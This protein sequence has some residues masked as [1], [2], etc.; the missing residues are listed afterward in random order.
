MI[1][2]TVVLTGAS[3]GMGKV[4]ALA[5]LKDGYKVI[6][7]DINDCDIKQE[8][9]KFI[10][11]DLTN[12]L[13]RKNLIEQIHNENNQIYAII[14]LAGIFMME[15][16]VEG[17]SEHLQKIIDVNF[18]SSYYLNK[19][20]FSLLDKDSRII[21]MSSELARYSPQPFMAYY[22]ISKKMVDAYTDALRR[23]CNYIGIKVIKIQSGSM[24]T[25]MLTKANNEYEQMV[26]KTKYFTSPLNKMKYMMDRELKKNADP[27]IIANLIVK[28]LNS[29]KPK[30]IYRVK[31]SFALKAMNM[32]PENLQDNIYKKVIK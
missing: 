14:N 1:N 16:I 15:S 6:G 29:K 26:S 3:G 5:L 20:L 11:A 10:K 21:N 30:I 19:G 7:I 23:E 9:F 27:A 17:E 18:F 24:K 2:K 12:S 32:L 8:N 13:D 28:I 4:S 25:K 22:A 31:N